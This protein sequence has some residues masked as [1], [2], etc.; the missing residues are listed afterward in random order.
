MN[1]Q[2]KDDQPFRHYSL[3]HRVIAWVSRTLFDN[4]TYTV[5]H[6]L[7]RGMKR[8]GGLGWVPGFLSGEIESKETQFWASLDLRGLVI[9]DVGA[10]QGLVALFFCRQAKLVVSYE[11]NSRNY[12]RLMENLALNKVANVKVRNVGVGSVP[13]RLTM[14]STPLMPGGS[15][16]DSKGKEQLLRAD[17]SV[18]EE[19]EITTLDQEVASGMPVPDFIKIDIEGWELEALKGARQTLLDHHPA[20]YLEMHGETMNEKRRK[21]TE[22]VDYLLES[23]YRDIRH[24]ETDTALTQTNA[25]V[26]AEGHLYC[27]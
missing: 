24:V 9:Y 17:S 1:P 12:R 7:L 22:I 16:V 18:T 5:R 21:V 10:F 8:K 15:T 11:P 6:G 13:Q 2:V 4:A 25:A 20:L 14:V 27:R 26:A 23:G 3:K 19:I